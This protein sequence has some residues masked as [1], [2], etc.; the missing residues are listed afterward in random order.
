MTRIKALIAIIGRGFS[1]FTIVPDT[2]Y[3]DIVP[4][5]PNAISEAA[6]TKTGN[7]LRESISKVGRRIGTIEAT[8]QG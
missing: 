6:W 2:N 1:T 8:S 3:A 4:Q 7:S 5:S